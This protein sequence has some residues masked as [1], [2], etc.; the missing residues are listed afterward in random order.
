MKTIPLAACAGLC[1]CLIP[2]SIRADAYVWDNQNGNGVWNDPVNWGVLSNPD[3]NIT[4]TSADS[5][6][7]RSSSPPGTVI[8]TNNGFAQKIRQ[9]TSA[10]ARVITIGPSETVNRTLAL[11]GTATEL[12]ECT[13]ASADLTLDGTPNAQGARLQLVINGTQT[14]CLVN[15]GTSLILNCDVSGTNGIS[16]NAGNS[17]AGSLV[18]GGA[19]TYTGPTTVNAGTLV[20]NGS[21]AA[22]SAVTVNSGGTLTGTGVLGG[23]VTVN[24]G[25]LL[26]PGI[27]PS[28]VGAL[29]VGG[30][31]KL[32]GNL[33]IELDKSLSPSNDLVTV[34][35]PITNIG[36]GNVTLRNL[37][38]VPLVAGDSFKIFNKPVP[39]GQALHVIP[40]GSEVWTNKLAVDGSIA[41]LWSTNSAVAGDPTTAFTWTGNALTDQNWGT[42]GNWM[43]NAAPQP[44]SSNII[45]FQGDIR[46]PY[47]W[48]YVDTNYGTTILIFS[49][50]IAL[51]GIKILAGIGHTMNFGSYVLQNQPPDAQSPCYFGIDEPIAITWTGGHSNWVVNANFTNALGDASVGGQTEFKCVGGRLDVYGVLKDGLGAHS[52]LVKSG[53]KTLNLCG[54]HANVYTGG[55]VVN[56]GPIKMA[57]PAGLN[58]IPGDVTVNSTGALL[59]N[60]GGG[61]QVADTAIVTLNDSGSLSLGG[62]PETVQ[63]VQSASPGASIILGTGG[64]LTVAPSASV[65]YSNGLGE[66]DF[67]GSIS[68]SGTLIKNGTGT[69][70]MLGVN[71]VDTLTVNSGTLKVNGNSGAGAVTVKAGGTLLGV[72]TIAGP[73]SVAGGGTIG[74]GF[75]AGLLTVAAGLD[76]SAGGNGA[77]NVWELAALKDGGTGVAGIDYDQVALNGG[78]LAIGSQASLALRFVGSATAPDAANVFWQSAHTWVVIALHGGSNPGASNFGRLKDANY[79]AGNFST[80]AD[81]NGNITLTFTPT[82]PVPSTPPTISSITNSAPGTVVVRYTN[83]LAGASYTLAYKTNLSNTA[84]WYPAGS[85]TAAGT[86]DSQTDTSATNNQRYYRVQSP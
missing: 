70:G 14:A 43:G 5:A 61:E 51:N 54:Q 19:N 69:F 34:A 32:A 6:I 2:F 57:K 68:G 67:S 45:V 46:V 53:D 10:P 33:F 22:A 26:A 11:S 83:T 63:T 27:P 38:A 35:G 12:I 55:T 9:N 56:A 41:V 39:N 85:K 47:N 31:L 44:L 80:A 1:A 77:T 66:S 37:G 74:A 42:P 7:F 64:T 3:T 72:G 28:G 25:G 4:P 76:L 17:G 75:G 82:P 79:A 21:L 18:L 48:P 71:S 36:T 81:V 30:S 73:V 58:A 59:M 65:T 50:N 13:L 78:T 29:T 23:S 49:N 20:V 24:A 62:Q 60:N 52:R 40:V 86:S 84:G 15:G 8:L 16:L